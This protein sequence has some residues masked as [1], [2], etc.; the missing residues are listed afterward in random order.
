MDNDSPTPT[1]RST[2]HRIAHELAASIEELDAAR[3]A[4]VGRVRAADGRLVSSGAAPARDY[5]RVRR[6]A[7]RVRLLRRV[8]TKRSIFL[9]RMLTNRRSTRAARPRL[10]SARARRASRATTAASSSSAGD[11]DPPAPATGSAN[12][13]R[14]AQGG[15]S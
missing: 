11:G 5:G 13:T 8:W 10:R 9:A 12:A 1:P 15:A 6:A 4:E 7:R 2:D 14:A 3:L